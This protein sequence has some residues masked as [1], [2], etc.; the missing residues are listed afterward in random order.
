LEP[1]VIREGE[2]R[3]WQRVLS[4]E[5]DGPADDRSI[6]FYIDE[7]GETGKTWFQQWYFSAHQNS[8]QI[9]GVGRSVDMA[10]A[11]DANK[12]VFLINVPRDGMQFFQ[13]SIA[14]QLKDRM[15]FSTKYA[16]EMK[17]LAQNTH[18]IIFANEYPDESKLSADRIIIRQDY[19][20]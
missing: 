6:I 11:V 4:D 9:L 12:H 7:I 10:F 2:P 3:D 18:V 13:Y 1:P 14:E 15:V 20:N 8:C 17:I 16:S 19:N 5:L